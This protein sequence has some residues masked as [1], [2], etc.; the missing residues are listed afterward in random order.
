MTAAKSGRLEIVLQGLG[1]T[2]LYVRRGANLSDAQKQHGLPE[3]DLII[4]DEAHRTTGATLEGWVQSRNGAVTLDSNS[5]TRPVC[6]PSVTTTAPAAR[7][8][9]SI[10]I[11]ANK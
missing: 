1:D 8:T 6:L 10:A 9:A 5:V 4:C 11:A 2:S 3:F 7:P